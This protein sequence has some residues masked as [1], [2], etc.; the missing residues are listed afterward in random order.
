V[1]PA[2]GRVSSLDVFRGI[3]IF[4]MILANTPGPGASP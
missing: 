4:P 1:T 3:T 2:T